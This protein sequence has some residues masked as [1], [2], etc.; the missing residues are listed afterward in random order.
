MLRFLLDTDHLTLFEQEHPQLV[1]RIG[2][3]A[4][5]EVAVSSVTVE[6]SLRGRVAYLARPLGGPERVRGYALLMNSVRLF[7]QL[8]VVLFDDPCEACF[9]QLRA[10]RIR[11]GS[12][13]LRI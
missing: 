5:G 10:Q 4:V 11:V 1:Q 2:A 13:D 7:S 8:P 3:V 12:Q 6:E 9:Q